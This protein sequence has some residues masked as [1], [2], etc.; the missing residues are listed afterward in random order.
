MADFARLKDKNGI[1]PPT[2]PAQTY[3][4]QED[5]S[6]GFVDAR[7]LQTG[8]TRGTQQ[9]KGKLTV[10]DELGRTRIVIG[11]QKGGF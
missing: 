7:K 2:Y 6:F 9:I 8:A 1:K 3:S 5:Q 10:V 4:G 11:Y